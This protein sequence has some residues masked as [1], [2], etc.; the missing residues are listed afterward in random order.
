MAS[1]RSG[2]KKKLFFYSPP[3]LFSFFPKQEKTSLGQVPAGK[4]AAE[5]NKGCREGR[6]A[7]RGGEDGPSGE[8][9]QQ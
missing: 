4:A 3:P 2:I 8:I 1:E 6:A 7:V 5:G 9:G